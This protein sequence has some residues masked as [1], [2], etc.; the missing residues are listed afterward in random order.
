[1]EEEAPLRILAQYVAREFLKH[2]AFLVVAFVALYTLFDFIEKVDNFQ[3]AGQ[4]WATMLAFFVLQVPEITTLLLPLAVLM[5]TVITLA[6][7]SKHNEI[8]AVKSSGISLFRFTLP[9]LLLAALITLGLAILNEVVVPHTKARTNYIWDVL[10]EKRPRRL[11][12]KEKFWFKGQGSIYRVGYYDPLSQTLSDV[13]WYRFDRDFNLVQRVDAR[14]V[15]FLGGRWVAFE[16]LDQRRLPGGGY[17][18]RPF[19]ETVLEMP[20]RPQD[21]TRL[22]KPSEEMTF[23]ELKRY[24]ERIE[25]EGYNA[26]RYRVDLQA[27]ISYPFVCLIMALLGIPLA[28]FREHGRALAPAILM[29]LG[30]A[31]LYWIGFSYARSLFGYSGV[32]PPFAAVWLCNFV[33]A[34]AGLWLFTSI[35]Q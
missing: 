8:V 6:L 34:V 28:L 3:E 14:R 17:A 4:G 30:A 19:R 29:G 35:R 13:T 25:R 7:M 26:R 20:E 33:F 31:L 22:A 12:H 27:R 2:F 10:V 5:A 1:V 32:L 21:F 11:T 23:L 15:R 9:I 18:V 24:V 16:G